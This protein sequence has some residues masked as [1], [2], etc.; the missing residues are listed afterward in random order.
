VEEV[1]E[2]CVPVFGLS[3]LGYLAT[4][5]GWFSEQ[6]AEGLARFVFDWAVPML[7]FRL[8]S[9]QSLPPQFPWRLL[10]SFYVPALVLYGLVMVATAVI[11]R[12]ETGNRIIA[13]LGSAYGNAVLLGLPLMLLAFGDEGT[14]PYLVLV[15][16]HMLLLYSIS[17][18]LL[19]LLRHQWAGAG[20]L[21]S[22]V[23]KGLSSN[24]ILIGIAAGLIFNF[25]GFNLPGPVDRI[26]QYMQHAVAAC[27]LFALGASLT[28]YNIAGHL[29]ETFFV[30]LAK[31]VVLP[32]FVWGV[33]QYVLVLSTMETIAAVMFAAQP[34]GIMVYLF[35]ERYGVGQR[36]ATTTIF[37][38]SIVSIVTVTVVLALVRSLL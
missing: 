22:S 7:L 16:V 13:A 19:E 21:S 20:R 28:R 27:S 10:L 8:F 2:I 1:L 4:R 17:S 26:T 32:V 9:T 11:F 3:T 33:A 25:S 34:T 5:I 37:I 30:V 14:V 23:A 35:A 29:P 36:L 6:S 18:I 15:S 24:P 31:N 38:S 12:L